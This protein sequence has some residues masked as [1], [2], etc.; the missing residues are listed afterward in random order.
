MEA[1]T[2]ADLRFDPNF[3]LTV[4]LELGREQSVQ[5]LMEKLTNSM[6]RRSGAIARLEIWLHERGD[7]CSRCP[8]RPECPDQTR[9]LHLVADRNYLLSGSLDRTP[10]SYQSEIRMPLGVGIIGK[11]ATTGQ[12]VVLEDLDHAPPELFPVEWLQREQIRAFPGNAISFKGEVLG[13]LTGFA[14]LYS[15]EEA[16]V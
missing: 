7:I 16:T 12:G 1:N 6:V 8:R 9:C 14:R 11:I 13:V 15:M 10:P 3:A 4:L 5:A 2:D